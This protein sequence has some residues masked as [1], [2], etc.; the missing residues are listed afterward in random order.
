MP[1]VIGTGITIGGGISIVAESGGGA[2]YATGGNV[3]DIAG[4]KVHIIAV[5]SVFGDC[6]A[7]LD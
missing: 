1:I 5:R 7:R 6:V 4:F 3:T 2:T